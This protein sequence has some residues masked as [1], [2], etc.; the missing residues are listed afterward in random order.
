MPVG[1]W[2]YMTNEIMIGPNRVGSGAFGCG[3]E[4]VSQL[5]SSLV[6][7]QRSLMTMVT[8]TQVLQAVT[9]GTDG[10][11]AGPAAGNFYIVISSSRAPAASRE[12][13]QQVEAKE[14]DA[15]CAGVGQCQTLE[16]GAFDDGVGGQRSAF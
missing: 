16:E 15:R 6:R 14:R 13:A 12:L 8:S 2:G 7:Q 10:I 11:L 3:H 1:R 5:P 4:L 9:N